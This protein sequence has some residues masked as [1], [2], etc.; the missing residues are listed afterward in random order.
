MLYIRNAQ[1][2]RAHDEEAE[3]QHMALES[4]IKL[5]VFRK[6]ERERGEQ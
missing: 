2:Y 4:R 6:V 5:L 1:T 3:I